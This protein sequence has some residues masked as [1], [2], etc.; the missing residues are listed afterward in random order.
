[1]K[2]K[3]S[4]WTV[5]SLVLAVGFC[6][7][8]VNSQQLQAQQ[9]GAKSLTPPTLTA[10]EEEKRNN[11]NIVHQLEFERNRDRNYRARQNNGSKRA[12]LTLEQLPE[13]VRDEVRQIAENYTQSVYPLLKKYADENKGILPVN[14]VMVPGLSTHIFASGYHGEGWPKGEAPI[15]SIISNR[16]R[17]DGTMIARDVYSQNAPDAPH[18]RWAEYD[19]KRFLI[20]GK[21]GADDSGFIISGWDD[22]RVT[23]DAIKDQYYGDTELLNG[24]VVPNRAPV[25]SAGIPKTLPQGQKAWRD[26]DRK[27]WEAAGAKFDKPAK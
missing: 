20:N 11:A 13:D 24:E 10:Q 14:P 18:D 17:M 27:K 4:V 26:A 22:G 19:N 6:V 9:Q 2:I 15:W 3:P 1:M 16:W 25:G 8:R 23:F 7:F 21:N 12:G 5:A